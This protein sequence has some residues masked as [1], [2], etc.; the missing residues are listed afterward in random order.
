[1]AELL[2]LFVSATQDLE[3]ER[4]VIGRALA[5][6]PVQIG[7]EIRRTPAAGASFES[8]HERIANVD[9]FY[10]LMGMDISAPAGAEWNLAWRLERP[11]L[12]LRRSGRMTPAA[13]QFVREVIGEWV[14]FGSGAELAK[15][16]VQDVLR[17]LHHPANRYGLTVSELERLAVFAAGV[18]RAAVV[19][20]AGDAEGAQG[21][22]VLLDLGHRE[23][24][25]GTM[26]FEERD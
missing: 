10:F 16:V 4:A 3:R 15:L 25:L 21:G 24:L 12:L 23:P 9:R 7:I 19:A 26:L 8:I 22:G 14:G 13:E 5:Q 17:M 20:A 18:E 2:R 1:M 6:V 11:V